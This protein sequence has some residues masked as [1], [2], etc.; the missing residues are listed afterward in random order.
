MS[1]RNARPYEGKTI[2]S[3]QRL[4]HGLTPRYAFDPQ[5]IPN[6][7]QGLRE[8][9]AQLL[10]G[11]APER[12]ALRPET[13]MEGSYGDCALEK[14]VYESERGLSIP[15]YLLRPDPVPKPL[16]ALICLH[17][18]G[19]GKS[20]TVGFV[21]RGRN[22]DFAWQLAQGGYIALAPDLRG[23]GEREEDEAWAALAGL[24]MDRP[25]LG[26]HVW[27]IFRSIDYLES[28]PDV[29]PTK[30]GIV[31]LGLGGWVALFSAALDERLACV[32]GSNCFGT[33]K[34]ALVDHQACSCWYVP[35]LAQVADLPD[36][37]ALI[38][39][40]PLFLEHAKRHPS[41]LLNSVRQAFLKLRY[42]YD[43]IGEGHKIALE[44]FEGETR[45]WGPGAFAWIGRWLRKW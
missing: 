15:A 24:L 35:G 38:A 36:V 40:R 27:D 25:L 12:C 34:T 43:A 45:F 9:L 17:D 10:G 29:D 37:A 5:D 16:P 11:L 1:D 41:L 23:C 33:F 26:R 4:A 20:E 2:A 30:I 44:I 31:G 13:L 3:L 42:A 18:H 28:R 14:V 22:A 32:V 8:V 39:P 19:P 6:W 7:R 21:D